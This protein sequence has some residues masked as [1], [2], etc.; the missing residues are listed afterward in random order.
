M[1]ALR[2]VTVSAP[3]CMDG[4]T[5][6]ICLDHLRCT[7]RDMMHEDNVRGRVGL[8][9]AGQSVL[10]PPFVAHRTVSASAG[11]MDR[12][13]V[14]VIIPT[15]GRLSLLPEALWS[16]RQQTVPVSQLLVIVDN[17]DPSVQA[18]VSALGEGIA[19]FACYTLPE[20]RGV[21]AARNLGLEHATG[22]YVV[23][24]D[25]DDLLH[26]EM[27]ER[28]LQMFDAEPGL[29]VAVGRYQVL[30]TPSALA[31]YPA[32]F[33]FNYRQSATDPLHLVDRA[34]HV[35][36]Q[37]L[38]TAPVTAF[39]R[40]LI[41]VNSCLVKRTAIGALRFPLE[42]VHGED[43]Y[44]WVR[45]AAQGCTFRMS[46]AM[47]AFVRRHGGN[48]TRS[49]TAYFR[50]IQACYRALQAETQVTVAADRFLIQLKLAYFDWKTRGP[51]S[52]GRQ[53]GLLRHPELLRQEVVRFVRTTLRDRRQLLRY[54]FSA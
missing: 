33:P 3:Y 2:D 21:S 39:L 13:S 19:G 9:G 52:L 26:P 48:T 45:L 54:Y 4:V 12:P 28:A 41:P 18:Q 27:V 16:V 29:G 25:D 35:P 36:A 40:Y 34:N 20:G 46:A 24:L 6:T 10:E 1:L 37:V 23:F 38:A 30:F 43:T 49:A 17:P 7:V 5:W 53:L 47:F 50:D 11:S 15:V 44:F 8:H 51:N 32:V 22:E 14:T 42:L 31:E